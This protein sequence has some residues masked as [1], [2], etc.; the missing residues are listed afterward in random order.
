MR[1]A[2]LWRLG[3]GVVFGC[4]SIIAGS[5]M[6]ACGDDA[7]SVRDIELRVAG[8]RVS[9]I[10]GRDEWTVELETA[11]LAFGPLTLCPGRSAGEFCDTAR[12]EW[13]DAVVVNALEPRTKRAG[14]LVA[15]TGPVLSFMYDY[16]IV[17]LLT[18]TTPY[19]TDAARELAG[20]SV[21]LRGCATKA[22]QELCFALSAPIAQ[23]NQTEQGVPVVRVNGLRGLADLTQVSRLTA[24]FDPTSWVSSIDFDAIAREFECENRCD[25]E[26]TSGSQA[27]RAVQTALAGSARAQLTWAE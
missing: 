19:I 4:S 2:G 3:S 15:T 5:A 23:T 26:L 9:A 1:R 27:A 20:N 21:E 12:G 25:V 6:V 7:V 11:R 8:A 14:Y 24:T 16:G 17:S 18:R 13:V 22:G 10:A